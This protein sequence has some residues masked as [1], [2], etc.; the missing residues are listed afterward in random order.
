MKTVHIFFLL[1]PIIILNS[2]AQVFMKAAAIHSFAHIV[3]GVF[4]IWF[5]VAVGCQGV[6]FFFWQAAL[7]QKQ[8]SFL[9]PF[10]SLIYIIVPAL[11]VILFQE[12]VTV[13][14][15]VGICCIITGV[16]ITSLGVYPQN[17][18][19]QKEVAR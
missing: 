19:S 16:C 6:S 11:S 2:V 3:S 13:K 8:L 5:I 14:Y 9:H 12:T 18:I 7:R 1:F 10:L 15:I 17:S 4:N